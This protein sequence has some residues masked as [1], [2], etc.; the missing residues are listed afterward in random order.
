MDLAAFAALGAVVPRPAAAFRGGLQGPAIEHH[1]GM[2]GVLL[3]LAQE[4]AQIMHDGFKDA[5]SLPAAHPSLRS[6]QRLLVDGVMR[7]QIMRQHPPLG[8][9]AD[10]PAQAVEELAQRMIALRRVL[11]FVQDS[12]F[13]H[14]GEVRSDT[15][16]SSSLTSL[17]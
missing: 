16:P 10:N 3:N 13:T 1:R 11:H 8:S 2:R 12:V 15:S 17:G 4:P 9:R 5:R 14:Q 6:G 7:G